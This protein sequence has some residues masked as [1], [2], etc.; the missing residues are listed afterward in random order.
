MTCGALGVRA[1]GGE[2][3]GA[4][5]VPRTDWRVQAQHLEPLAIGFAGISLPDAPEVL[6]FRQGHKRVCRAEWNLDKLELAII[7]RARKRDERH[8]CGRRVQH[9][10]DGRRVR[11]LPIQPEIGA[12]ASRDCTWLPV[13]DFSANV[14]VERCEPEALVSRNDDRRHSAGRCP[15]RQC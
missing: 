7:E 6:H 2:E 3:V 9:E 12:R 13:E 4:Q 1:R 10:R 8:R 11:A 15:I 14:P 5:R